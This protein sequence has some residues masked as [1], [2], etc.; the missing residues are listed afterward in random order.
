MVEFGSQKMRRS[1]QA[2]LVTG[3]LIFILAISVSGCGKKN[4]LSLPP[5]EAVQTPAEVKEP[6]LRQTTKQDT[7]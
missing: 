2:T 4:A 3:A 7:P 5:T 1:Q 6:T